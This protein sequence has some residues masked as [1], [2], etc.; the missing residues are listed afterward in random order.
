MSCELDQQTD[1]FHLTKRQDRVPPSCGILFWHQTNEES[2]RSTSHLSRSPLKRPEAAEDAEAQQQLMQRL[3]GA[4][5]AAL[6]GSMHQ[7]LG[8]RILE[9]L[10]GVMW[11]EAKT[12]GF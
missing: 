1:L 12:G 4:T 8:R 5:A 11:L 2:H 7:A 6:S 3:S 9:P 10:R